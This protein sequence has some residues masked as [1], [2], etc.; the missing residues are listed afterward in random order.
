MGGDL[1]RYFLPSAPPTAQNT[2]FITAN[3]VGLG[4]VIVLAVLVTISNNIS[5][6]RLGLPRWKSVQRKVYIAAVAAIVHGL[7]YQL[8]E[9]R[10]TVLVLFVILVSIAV[11]VLQ[12]NGRRAMSRPAASRP[13]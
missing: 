11:A 3:Y 9:K 2:A 6:R 4:S 5:I 13:Q 12:L 10:M 7:L 1:S 8:L